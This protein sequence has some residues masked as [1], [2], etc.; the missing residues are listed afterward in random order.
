MTRASRACT[1][2]DNSVTSCKN[3]A[4]ARGAAAIRL[5]AVIHRGR[6]A[7]GRRSR[8]KTR[9]VGR[10]ASRQSTTRKG[11]VGGRR[12]RG[13]RERSPDAATAVRDEQHSAVDSGGPLGQFLNTLNRRGMADQFQGRRPANLVS[14][15]RIT[16]RRCI[17]H[18]DTA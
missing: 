3:S 7:Y 14:R 16:Q 18:T 1:A 12:A 5:S 13:H 6:T 8:R 17:W 4:A 2:A 9:E 11:A 15:P 10:I